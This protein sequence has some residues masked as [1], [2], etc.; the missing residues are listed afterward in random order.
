MADPN[1]GLV[2]L[3]V[4]YDSSGFDSLAPKDVA[5]VDSA[6]ESITRSFLAKQWRI[7]HF[8]QSGNLAPMFFFG[9]G[10]GSAAE[11]ELALETLNIDP[12]DPSGFSTWADQH[13]LIWNS[14]YVPKMSAN[15]NNEVT[16]SGWRAFP[17]K[18]GF[19]FTNGN[20]P[21]L[22]AYNVTTTTAGADHLMTGIYMLRGVWLD[23]V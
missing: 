23:D 4:V 8:G 17:G 10:G 12:T 22:F 5:V 3:P 7:I 19:P 18:R 20:G 14:I 15:E 1:A 21:V 13:M 9:I 16:D 11:Q 2:V 6:L